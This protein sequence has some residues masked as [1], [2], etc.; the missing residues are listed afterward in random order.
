MKIKID[1]YT[2][3]PGLNWDISVV[4]S[5]GRQRITHNWGLTAEIALKSQAMIG[6]FG[7]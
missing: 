5:K 2:N 6:S 1:E 3:V 7:P 4:K